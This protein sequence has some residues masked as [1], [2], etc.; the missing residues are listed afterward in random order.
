MSRSRETHGPAFSIPGML[1]GFFV[2]GIFLTVFFLACIVA[3][4]HH[5]FKSVN[6]PKAEFGQMLPLISVAILW[7]P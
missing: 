3:D 6:I 1:N 5:C 7:P 4:R 2:A